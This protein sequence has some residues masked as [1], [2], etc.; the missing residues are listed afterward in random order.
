LIPGG[1][2]HG[3]DFG[4]VTFRRADDL[5]VLDIAASGLVFKP[6]PPRL[7][8]SS[9]EA[10]IV[11]ALPPQC[12]GEEAFLTVAL[13]ESFA[14][15]SAE[16]VEVSSHPDYPGKN[17]PGRRQGLPSELPVARMRMSG[18]SRIAVDMPSELNLLPLTGEALLAALRLWPMRLDV[19]AKPDGSPSLGGSIVES[20]IDDLARELVADVVRNGANGDALGHAFAGAMAVLSEKDP[21]FAGPRGAQALAH[22]ASVAAL[23]SVN[24]DPSFPLDAFLPLLGRPR[25]AAGDTTVLELPYRI[26]ISPLDPARW[27][28]ADVPVTRNGR[29]ELWHSRLGTNEPAA[30]GADLASRIRALWSPDYRPVDRLDELITLISQQ[31]EPPGGPEPNPD[32]IRMS[33]DPV[34]RSMLVTLMAGYDARREGGARY[35]PLSS[36]AKRL[37]VSA[38][39][40]LLDA[41]GSWSALPEGIDLEQWRHLATLGRD[42]YVRV[43]Y[44]GYLYP[45]GHAASLVKVTERQFETMPGPTKRRIAVL[46]QRFYV[47]VR[48]PIRRFNGGSHVHGG[49]DFPFSEVEILTRLTPDLAE[50]GMGAGALLSPLPAGLLPRMLFWP[51][52]HGPGAGTLRD[53]HFDL[54]AVDLAGQRIV[55]SMPLLFVG[56]LADA[57]HSKAVKTAY[58]ATPPARRRAATGSA[59]VAFA[60]PDPAAELDPRLPAESITFRAGDL[61]STRHP[62]VFPEIDV[63]SVGLTPIQKLLGRPAFVVEATYPDFYRA[64]GFAAAS[65][66]GQIFLQLTRSRPLSFGGAPDQAKSD[67]LG[68]LASPAMELLGLSKVMGP[69]SGTA[70]NDV[71]EV[72]GALDKVRRATFDPKEFFEG[73][74]I[75]GGIPIAEILD[76]TQ[77]L[78][79][80]DVPKMTSRDLPDRIEARF[81]WETEIAKSDPLKLLVPHA[82]PAGPRS[83]LVMNGQVTTM[84]EAAARPSFRS[85]A[86]LDNFKVNLFG[87]VILWFEQL[88]FSAETGRKPDVLVELR[89]GEDAV[90]FGGPLEFVNELRRYVPSNGFSDPPALSV[91]PSG[92]RSSFSLTLP[93]VQVGIFAL[94]NAALG[95]SFDLPFDA[96]PASV[97]FSFSER[98]APF[99]LTV[100]LLGGGGFLAV[101]ISAAGVNEIEAALEFGAMIAI[102]LGVASGSVEVKAGIYFH[103]LEPVPNKGS[104]DLAGYVR[105]HGELTIIALISVSLTFNLQLGYHKEAGKASVY[106][107]ATLVVEVEILMFSA[108]VAVTCRREFA[109]GAADPRFVDLIPDQS[110]WA[111]YC[112]AFATEAA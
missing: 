26:Q 38:L 39:G 78:G 94:S 88:S 12:F 47:V 67:A 73:A 84:R 81:E 85:D 15:S 63:T 10:F 19:N 14:P 13:D 23:E 72:V 79:G 30:V 5:V 25:P 89:Q 60:P 65:N 20:G 55:A 6:D 36:E 86:V 77:G 58:G 69:V 17:V 32:L 71:A 106:G 68:A 1:D 24:I 105:I 112:N 48:E 82:D 37:H 4:P 111:E 7:E 97:R 99:S 29:T 21:M 76:V 11:F 54:A 56:K 53:F 31:P 70:G 102:D 83:R 110:V 27:H 107:E 62:N 64:G 35:R 80:A 108:E 98:H 44:K 2:E 52:V 41:E 51:M 9:A 49:R 57:D 87:F 61:L 40:A 8:R 28:H 90:S 59:V 3:V 100:S 16:H 75:L 66:A 18:I 96:R 95:A 42:H 22:A 45:F 104:V 33:L 50:P 92:I 93:A 91:T 109:G 101:G 43:V 103:W 46:R 34:D 74:T